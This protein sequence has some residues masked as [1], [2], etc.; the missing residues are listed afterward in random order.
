MVYIIIET[1]NKKET[2][3][4]K[5]LLLMTILLVPSIAFAHDDG[6]FSVGIVVNG[7]PVEVFC[8]ESRLQ[9]DTLL[10][11]IDALILQFKNDPNQK[12][13]TIQGDRGSGTVYNKEAISA[14]YIKNLSVDTCAQKKVKSEPKFEWVRTVKYC[15]GWHCGGHLEW[16]QI[17]V[18]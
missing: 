5:K 1:N 7:V 14:T 2:T 17:Q 6:P 11:G 3:M 15:G 8:S 9:A 18:K 12:T 16:V 13:I 10:K 4:L